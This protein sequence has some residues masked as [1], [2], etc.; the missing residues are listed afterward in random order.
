MNAENANAAKTSNRKNQRGAPVSVAGK[1]RTAGPVD[2]VGNALHEIDAVEY[3]QFAR[4][5]HLVSAMNRSV[6]ERKEINDLWE[7]RREL[8]AKK[9]DLSPQDAA[10]LSEL[11][12]EREIA[13][14]EKAEKDQE[15]PYQEQIDKLFPIRIGRNL[16]WQAIYEPK[17]LL[18]RIK[19]TSN[20]KNQ[21]PCSTQDS[22]AKSYDRLF[23][24]FWRIGTELAA[25]SPEGWAEELLAN[26]DLT[27]LRLEAF[28]K[29]CTQ[30][31]GDA[32]R[33]A[34]MERELAVLDA[35]PFVH[36]EAKRR[37]IT[38]AALR[39]EVQRHCG[40]T[41]TENAADKFAKQVLKRADESKVKSA[42]RRK[43]T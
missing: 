13:E 34:K 42:L 9:R 26:P 31:R 23:V 30:L 27:L 21:L 40:F 16:V 24:I 8:R 35:E 25:A 38:V 18:A 41:G 12:N 29:G 3:A 5:K 20:R 15:H 10:R 22:A 17:P 11:L 14:I 33:G 43:S 37:K 39:H 2:E 1:C 28:V 7:E 4:W 19:R 32:P 6:P 36:A